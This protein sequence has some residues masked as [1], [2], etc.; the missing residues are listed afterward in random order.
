MSDNFNRQIVKREGEFLMAD[1]QIV[2]SK[3]VHHVAYTTRDVEATYEFYTQ[4]LGMRLLRTEN[5]RQGDGYFRHFFFGM[6]AGEAIAFFQMEGI[7]EEPDFKTEISTGLG[8]P[9]WA[10]HIAFRLD[11]L[12]ELET[13]TKQ[14]HGRGIEGIMRVD[15]GWCTSIYTLDPNGIMVEFC[16]T[17]DAEEFEQTEEEALRLMRLLPSEFDEEERKEESAGKLV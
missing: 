4:K 7:G 6:G 9:P 11:T 14:L 3:S 5:H 10:N 16:V 1:P 17:T 2:E 12:E 8:L 15:H 13:M